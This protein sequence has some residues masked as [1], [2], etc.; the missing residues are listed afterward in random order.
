MI[1]IVESNQT[2]V[3]VYVQIACERRHVVLITPSQSIL[4]SVR[5][6]LPLVS[7][8]VLSSNLPIT[9]SLW[10]FSRTSGVCP[11]PRFRGPYHVLCTVYR[12]DIVNH[13]VSI[14]LNYENGG[15]EACP[16]DPPWSTLCHMIWLSSWLR[17]EESRNLSEDQY[18]FDNRLYYHLQRLLD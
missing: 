1:F 12:V 15:G 17:K 8:P 14:I 3:K 6:S 7:H 5:W 16:K 11:G 10:P 4:L 9:A 18:R 13:N 2:F